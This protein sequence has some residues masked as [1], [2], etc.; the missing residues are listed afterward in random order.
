MTVKVYRYAAHKKFDLP[1]TAIEQ[2]F[3]AHQ[4][5]N[6]LVA[7]HKDHQ[8]AVADAWREHP[9]V[10]ELVLEVEELV[11]KQDE[12]AEAW[13][14]SKS[15]ARDRKGDPELK[16]AL[17][18]ARAKTKETRT[19]LK[20]KK[21]EA[22]EHLSPKFHEL[23]SEE[24]A[25]VKAKYREYIDKGLYWATFNLVREQHMRAVQAM[26]KTRS[27]GRASDLR[28]KRFTGEGQISVQLQREAN[29][30]QRTPAILAS[31]ESKWKNTVKLPVIPE[32]KQWL[33]MAIRM[34][35]LG[36]EVQWCEIPK[37][38]FHRQIPAEG[39]ITDVRVSRRRVAGH[40]RV[41]VEIT[42]KLPDIEPSNAPGIAGLNTGWRKLSDG[43]IRV[44]TWRSKEVV[45][46]SIP[47]KNQDSILVNGE[48]GEIVI[49]QH[50][51]S[52][53]AHV[54]ELAALRGQNL[55]LLKA[56]LLTNHYDDLANYVENPNDIKQWRSPNRFAWLAISMRDSGTPLAIRLEDWRRQDRHLWEWEANERQK[57]VRWRKDLF[58]TLGSLLSDRCSKIVVQAPFVAKVKQSSETDDQQA[59]AAR[60]AAQ[61][62]AP[63]TLIQAL[64]LAA[65]NRGAEVEVVDSG[66][67]TLT[68]HGCGHVNP[69]G[70]GK[71]SI[72]IICKNCGDQY[73]QDV[74]AA[75]MLL[76]RASA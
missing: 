62:A 51:V 6:D 57:C 29:Q 19:E 7:I 18:E 21:Q 12:I 73:D 32:K 55:E 27:Q 4:L 71:Q 68:H 23:H 44:G 24:K 45:P 33:P 50:I 11:E 75:W 67:V 28:F 20:I 1:K 60:K 61:L 9:E 40:F 36:D 63:T 30:P 37:V 69:P 53:W 22:Y 66:G 39:D 10:E 13:K 15:H 47:E 3:L 42:V 70:S 49:P 76:D 41:S 17:T 72:H 56:G 46:F 8:D 14:K 16:T 64:K 2:L 65:S 58:L 31:G 26:K 35:K 48:G 74:N 34:S 43:S 5:R 38:R 59:D 52:K 54:A 25:A